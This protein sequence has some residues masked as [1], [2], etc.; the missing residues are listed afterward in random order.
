MVLAC[1]VTPAGVHRGI[2]GRAERNMNSTKT[3]FATGDMAGL[4]E[5]TENVVPLV[6]RGLVI[7]R[8]T[9]IGGTDSRTV[10]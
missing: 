7:T 9:T 1:P 3:I 6:F 2:E 4:D 10:F 5:L 8:G